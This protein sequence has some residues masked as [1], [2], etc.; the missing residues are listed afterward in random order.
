MLVWNKFLEAKLLTSALIAIICLFQILCYYFP[1]SHTLAC[2][3]LVSS[4]PSSKW[5]CESVCGFYSGRLAGFLSLLGSLEE[6]QVLGSWSDPC[7][8]LPKAVI[9][10]VTLRY[11]RVVI[12]QFNR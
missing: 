2:F 5:F 4:C 10:R 8:P 12:K 9:S 11:D 7:G 3:V 6:K 1:P